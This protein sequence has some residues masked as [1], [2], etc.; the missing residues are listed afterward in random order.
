ML[1]VADETWGA[2]RRTVTSGFTPSRLQWVTRLHDV[3]E[4]T[5]NGN[6]CCR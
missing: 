2:G 5:Q 6:S 1:Y 3:L 4:G